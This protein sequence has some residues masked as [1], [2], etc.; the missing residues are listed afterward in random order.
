MVFP[1][2]G[3]I[4]SFHFAVREALYW[5]FNISRDQGFAYAVLVHIFPYGSGILLGVI[6]LLTLGLSLR[7]LV[8][9]GQQIDDAASTSPDPMPEAPETPSGLTH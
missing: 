5:G 2:T 1:A 4:G 9:R 8:S 3:G 7:G 6:A